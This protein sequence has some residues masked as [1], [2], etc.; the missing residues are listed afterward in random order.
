HPPGAVGPPR[1][2]RLRR[3]R[4]LLRHALERARVDLAG[5]TVELRQE[6][7]RRAPARAVREETVQELAD[8]RRVRDRVEREIEREGS[9]RPAAGVVPCPRGENEEVS[10]LEDDLGDFFFV[11]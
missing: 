11:E 8:D 7:F 10:R 2:E 3:V 6:R 9:G 1:S 4:E 5:Q